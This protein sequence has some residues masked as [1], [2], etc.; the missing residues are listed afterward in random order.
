MLSDFRVLS[1]LYLVTKK[2]RK[3]KLTILTLTVQDKEWSDQF[4]LHK[5]TCSKTCLQ[6]ISK[7]VEHFPL[8]LDLK[9]IYFKVKRI[10]H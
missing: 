4:H 10:L 8:D 9:E 3:M 7:P 2:E 5:F 6:H 1:V